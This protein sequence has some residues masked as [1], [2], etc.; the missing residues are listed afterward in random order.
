MGRRYAKRLNSFSIN[1][2]ADLLKQSPAWIKSYMTIV[3]L[4]TYMELKGGAV[5]N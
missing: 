3:G 5:W 4:R 2:A 1:T